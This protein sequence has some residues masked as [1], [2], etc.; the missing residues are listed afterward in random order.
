[1]CPKSRTCMLAGARFWFKILQH[2][3]SPVSAQQEAGLGCSGRLLINKRSDAGVYKNNYLLKVQT[4][5]FKTEPMA[6]KN[7]PGILA[8]TVLSFTFLAGTSQAQNAPAAASQAPHA[9][10]DY[11][12]A[13]W[14]VKAFGLPQG[15]TE[16]VVKIEKK[17]GQLTGAFVNAA[18]KAE[19]PFTKVEP[20]ATGLTAFFVYDNMDV[21]MK[22]ARKDEANITGSIMDMFE[23]KGTKA[24]Q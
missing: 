19:T 2:E 1:V 6:I 7:L 11:Y 8:L 21:F 23:L 14:N 18:T 16:M 17:E 13:T 22:F 4:T 3:P 9:P 12:V 15:D 24:S 20:T 5:T 10:E